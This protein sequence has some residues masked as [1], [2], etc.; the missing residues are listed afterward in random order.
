MR[1]GT[2]W[3]AVESAAAHLG[4]YRRVI[5]ASL[6]RVWENVLD[7]E[8][9]PHLHK[10]SFRAIAPIRVDRD[11]WRANVELADGDRGVVSIARRS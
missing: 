5:R 6:D 1:I 4:T 7:W 10:D 11:G 2:I 8:H 9:L 3:A